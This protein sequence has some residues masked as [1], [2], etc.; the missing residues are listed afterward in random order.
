MVEPLVCPHHAVAQAIFQE[1]VKDYVRQSNKLNKNIKS[2][3]SLVW[4]QSSD[5]IKTHVE[6]L[7]NYEDIQDWSAGLELLMA[8]QGIIF[9]VQDKKYK[10]LTAHLAKQPFYLFKQDKNMTVANYYEHFNCLIKLLEACGANLGDDE[11]IVQKVLESQGM[12]P[13][14]ATPMRR[15]MPRRLAMSGIMLS[16]S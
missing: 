9:N 10:V 8:I 4:G 14:V 13:D 1:Q 5:V 12:D 11:G 3:W 16:L 2:V 7:P 15:K 6:A